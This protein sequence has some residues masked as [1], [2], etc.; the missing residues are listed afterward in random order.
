VAT[1]ATATV[2]I[3][4]AAEALACESLLL[5]QEESRNAP[6]AANS[7][8]KIGAVDLRIQFP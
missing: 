2:G 1:L 7:K 4:G 5:P 6:N 8:G 3:S